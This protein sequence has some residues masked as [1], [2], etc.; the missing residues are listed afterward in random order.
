MSGVVLILLELVE[1]IGGMIF[2]ELV[3][4]IMLVWVLWGAVPWVGHL[5]ENE[6]A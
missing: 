1:G 3:E 4:K 6:R 2:L 5:L